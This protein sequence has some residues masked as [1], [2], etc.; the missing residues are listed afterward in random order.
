MFYDFRLVIPANTPKDSPKRERIRLTKGVIHKVEIRFPPGCAGLVHVVVRDLEQQVWPTNRDG[1]FSDDDYVISFVECYE[2][3]HPPFIFTLE[4]WNDDDT[5][6]HTITFR[7]GILP[8]EV[9]RPYEEEM[10]FLR[11]FRRLVGL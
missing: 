6:D 2:L 7:F 5:Y 3:E 11:R 8:R 4:G 9:V 10:G 1:D